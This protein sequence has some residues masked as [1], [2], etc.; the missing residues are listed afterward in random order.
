MNDPRLIDLETK[1]SHHDIAIEE[2]QQTMQAQHLA[3]EKLE[4]TLK[5]LTDRFKGVDKEMATAPAHEKPPHY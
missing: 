5:L 3:I 2:L 4:K 1:F